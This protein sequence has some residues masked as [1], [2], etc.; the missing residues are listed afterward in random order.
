MKKFSISFLINPVSGDGL[1]KRVFN[2]LPE[3][4]RAFDFHQSD[5]T[6]EF[7][8]PE[9]M[10]EQSVFLLKNSKRVIAVGGDGTMG[11]ILNQLRIHSFPDTEVGLIPLG[12]GNDL[13]RTLGIYNVYRERGLLACIKRLVRAGSVELDIWNINKKYTLSAYFSFG[14]DA[15]ILHKFHKLRCNKNFPTWS[16]ANKIAYFVLFLKNFNYRIKDKYNLQY[17]YDGRQNELKIEG[18]S[19]CVL[20]NIPSYAGGSCPFPPPNF[21]DGLINIT[22]FRSPIKYALGQTLSRLIPYLSHWMKGM[23]EN[24]LAKS[25]KFTAGDKEFFQIDGEDFSKKFRGKSVEI[26]L[27]QKVKMLDLRKPPF[28]VF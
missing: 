28:D 13:G 12:T 15:A 2:Q 5:W 8:N 7:T 20:S 10:D 1:G 27:A 3:I 16:L 19:C 23:G 9:K 22:V 26:Q 24:V 18:A 6:A 21:E 14:M 11:L 17:E 25:V 4:M